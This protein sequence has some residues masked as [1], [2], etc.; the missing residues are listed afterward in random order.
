MAEITTIARPYAEAVYEQALAAD[1]LAQW[2]DVLQALAVA[3]ST[4][5]LEQVLGNPLVTDDQLFALLID[6]VGADAPTEVQ[7]F[8][9]VL[10]ENERVAALP[11]IAELFEALKHEHEGVVDAQIVS[12]FPLDESQLRALVGD[13]ETRFNCKV[14]PEVEV[15]QSLIGGVVITVGDEVIDASVRGKLA[16]MSAELARI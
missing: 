11:A 2:S 13:L 5:A 15:D 14:N 3:A 10:I 6:A 1:K 4:P 9:R 12:A 8:V 16:A 7:N